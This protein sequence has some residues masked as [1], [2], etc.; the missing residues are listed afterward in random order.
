MRGAFAL[1]LLLLALGAEA[2][3][4]GRMTVL[5]ALGEPLR[6]EIELFATSEAEMT[7]LSARIASMAVYAEQGVVR[8]TALDGIVVV[9]EVRP[10]DA[11][12]LVL[13]SQ[14]VM[15]DPFL[16]LLVEVEWAGGRLLREYTA[17][18]DAQPA[19]VSPVEDSL[20]AVAPAASTA[21]PV[22]LVAAAKFA[23]GYET[24]PG[25]TL[26]GIATQLEAVGVSLEQVLVGLY[27]NNPHAFSGRNMNRLKAGRILRLPDPQILQAMPPQQAADEVRLHAADWDAYRNGLARAVTAEPVMTE[28]VPDASAE[29]SL[30]RADEVEQPLPDGATH[31]VVK[32]SRGDA[33]RPDAAEALPDATR[34]RLTLLQE[35]AV[36]R[37]KAVREA[38]ERIAA[39]EKQIQEM[40]RLLQVKNQSLAEM[41]PAA[42]ANL[43]QV[44]WPGQDML[45][46]LAASGGVVLIVLAA[47]W[48]YLRHRR[49]PVPHPASAPAPAPVAAPGFPGISLSL[50]EP[51]SDVVTTGMPA[52]NG[53]A[54]MDT[55]L[56][57]ATAYVDMGDHAGARALLQEVLE[58]GTSAQQERARQALAR[59]A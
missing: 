50:G 9:R 8:P 34:N 44:A 58:Q 55:R 31:D 19:T 46:M 15:T 1:C 33:V 35:E 3:S 38:N 21:P 11:R 48:V 17:L 52:T 43:L 20:P 40:Q 28:K 10:N 22:A 37:E 41:Q 51:D 25:D 2:A 29:G 32:I 56:D 16:D 13:Q 27:R 26:Q 24:R 42:D 18:L 14:Q 57:L 7:T 45:R 12:V 4:L 54:A 30:V 39:L 5:S 59:M 47:G 36:A 49:C 53:A 23:A 6:A